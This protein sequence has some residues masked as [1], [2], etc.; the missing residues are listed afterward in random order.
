[1]VYPLYPIVLLALLA[2]A[3]AAAQPS[4]RYG[5]VAGYHGMSHHYMEFGGGLVT[6]TRGRKGVVGNSLSAEVKMLDGV[7]LG[8][9][10][11]VWTSANPL[12]A[13]FSLSYYNDLEGNGSLRFRPEV[14]LGLG[15][16]R[17]VYGFSITLTGRELTAVNR[18]D[19]ALRAFVPLTSH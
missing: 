14:G 16:V 17:I 13:G 7:V 8:G 12:A 3:I 18:H 19:V 15:G 5:V 1:M 2:P 6:P 11:S 10:Y 9:T 4:S